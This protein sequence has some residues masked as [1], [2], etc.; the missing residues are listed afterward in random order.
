[1]P[2][3][4]V[5]IARS[6]GAVRERFHDELN[7]AIADGA[8]EG[9]ATGTPFRVPDAL[10]VVEQLRSHPEAR[11]SRGIPGDALDVSETDCFADAF[12][13]EPLETVVRQPFALAHFHLSVFDRPGGCLE[14]FG[15]QVLRPW[16]DALAQAGFT[17]DR[18]YPIIFVSGPGAATN[19]HT[20]HS[21]VVAWQWSGS[22]RF[23]SLREPSRW[24]GR[25]A[26][27]SGQL[28]RPP[29]LRDA[30]TL[31]MAMTPGDVLF[32]KLLTPHWVQALGEEVAVSL[33]I[34]H[35]GL[36]LDGEVCRNESELEQQRD[37]R[38]A[39]QSARY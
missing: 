38:P 16:E 15:E 11:I 8:L 5:E 25:E 23:C 13:A 36:R 26:R 4:R 29:A 24:A 33:N 20:D 9:W 3:G 6:W 12:R 28:E 21:H 34:S 35:G 39:V 1:M 2:A 30:D 19:Y 18:C 10:T 22:K 31:M 27:L 32:N 14:G 7:F 17:Y 37:G